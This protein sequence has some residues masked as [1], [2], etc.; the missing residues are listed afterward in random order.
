MRIN[1][2]ALVSRNLA[3]AD[4][5]AVAQHRDAIADAENLI[6]LVR[7]VDDRYAVPLQIRDQLEQPL[8]RIVEQRAGGL[9]HQDEPRAHAQRARDRQQLHL[10]DGKRSRH[11]AV[12]RNA[13]P[14]CSRNGRQNASISPN[15][16]KRR[17]GKRRFPITMFSPT[18]RCGNR[19]SS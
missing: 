4:R 13:S 19:S 7:D 2:S 16:T 3:R 11:L 18:V 15:R 5:F 9:V 17:L 6:H 12:N 8:R 14:T 10:A 1:S